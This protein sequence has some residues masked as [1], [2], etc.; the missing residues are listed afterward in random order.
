MADNIELLPGDELTGG[1]AGA[2]IRTTLA[3]PHRHAGKDYEASIEAPITLEVTPEA[4]ESLIRAGV[5]KGAE[6]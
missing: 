4:Y 1:P 5:L 3:K 6:K 2:R